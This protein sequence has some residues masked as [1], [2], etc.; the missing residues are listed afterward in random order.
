MEASNKFED[1]KKKVKQNIRTLISRNETDFSKETTSASE[2]FDTNMRPFIFQELLDFYDN[3]D[4]T[5]S[6]K[7]M[8]GIIKLDLKLYSD[9]IKE[10]SGRIKQ[11]QEKKS[12]KL[13]DSFKS[14]STYK[15]LLDSQEF[16]H[17]QDLNENYYLLLEELLNTFY[18][19]EFYLTPKLKHKKKTPV[20][21]HLSMA[22]V[23]ASILNKSLGLFVQSCSYL[24]DTAFSNPSLTKNLVSIG[25]VAYLGFNPAFLL[26]ST[27][28]KAY[29]LVL[30]LAGK[31]LRW[32]GLFDY[33]S[34]IFTYRDTT[35]YLGAVN[36]SLEKTISTLEEL[37]SLA[38]LMLE[39]Y[40]NSPESPANDEQFFRDIKE[41]LDKF[42]AGYSSVENYL[43]D[44]SDMQ[45]LQV[46]GEDGW[47]KLEKKKATELQQV[48]SS[49]QIKQSRKA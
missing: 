23:A 3:C 31:F 37:R 13:I 34:D 41:L 27:S 7:V 8:K 48:T 28:A 18:L 32:C 19:I 47:V 6:K 30:P 29:T 10:N 20:K 45:M 40:L 25:L 24:V 35:I 49:Y 44:Q 22:Y 12:W 36:E 38:I 15:S 26:A 39:E 46:E 33:I 9:F 2:A 14:S 4:P 5:D 43:S 1:A 16:K 42:G 11:T 17:N 21:S